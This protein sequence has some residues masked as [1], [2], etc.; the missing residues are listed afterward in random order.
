MRR[1]RTRPDESP[2]LA[3]CHARRDRWTR[4]QI[5][6]ADDDRRQGA[7]SREAVVGTARRKEQLANRYSHSPRRGLAPRGFGHAH[8]PA[9]DA[10][11]EVV[12]LDLLL[13]RSDAPAHG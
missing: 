3:A 12:V 1:A 4:H 8:R 2:S 10:T 7:A 5:T 9:H 11:L 13:A 6:C